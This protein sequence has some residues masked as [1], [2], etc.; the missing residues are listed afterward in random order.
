VAGRILITVALL[1]AAGVAWFTGIAQQQLIWISISDHV[2][3]LDNAGVLNLDAFEATSGSRDRLTLAQHLAVGP[4]QV[5]RCVANGI[6]IL[7]AVSAL[8]AFILVR[9]PQQRPAREGAERPSGP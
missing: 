5:V 2:V 3:G 8:V 6:A 4:V 1:V 7:L 9:A